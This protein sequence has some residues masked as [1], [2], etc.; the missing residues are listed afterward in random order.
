MADPVLR[1]TA[2]KPDRGP[3][4]LFF[5]HI[6]EWLTGQDTPP[7][8]DAEANRLSVEKIEQLDQ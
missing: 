6:A 7:R 4:Y 2:A 3:L 5:W 8:E 1:E